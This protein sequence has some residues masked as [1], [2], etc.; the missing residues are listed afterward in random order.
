MYSFG[1]SVGDNV[2]GPACDDCAFGPIQLSVPFIFYGISHSNI[3]VSMN[4]EFRND[5]H[6]SHAVALRFLAGFVT[7][8]RE[9]SGYEPYAFPL[10]GVLR[11]LAVVAPWWGE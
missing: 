10:V 7:F 2:A 9:F 8:S 6:I 5:V 4:G 11:N 3:Y 1:P